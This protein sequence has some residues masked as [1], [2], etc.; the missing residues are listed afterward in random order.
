[1]PG[2]R[3]ASSAQQSSRKL[4]LADVEW[5]LTFHHHCCRQFR[6]DWHAWSI[7][8]HQAG[9]DYKF[10]HRNTQE[11][12]FSSKHEQTRGQWYEIC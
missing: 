9:G 5:S 2:R 4:R 6:A 8:A 7:G 11:R 1:M 3:R 10:E 12:V